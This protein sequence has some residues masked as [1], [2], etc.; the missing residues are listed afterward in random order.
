[1]ALFGWCGTSGETSC[2]RRLLTSGRSSR[3]V[4]CDLWQSQGFVDI[5]RE[6]TRH[7]P[8]LG[9]LCYIQRD[10]DNHLMREAWSLSSSRHKAF[11]FYVDVLTTYHWNH[12]LPITGLQLV[13][14]QP[15]MRLYITAIYESSGCKPAPGCKP[16]PGCKPAPWVT[17]IHGISWFLWCLTSR[18]YNPPTN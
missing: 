13:V 1:M 18:P 5:L 7:Q 16:V 14:N 12:L 2:E 4:P 6:V 10:P 8:S 17:M 11:P 15:Q 9:L 3:L